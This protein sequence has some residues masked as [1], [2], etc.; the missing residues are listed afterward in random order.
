MNGLYR[1]DVDTQKD[2]QLLGCSQV[3]RLSLHDSHH[4]E[5]HLHDSLLSSTRLPAGFDSPLSALIFCQS[6]LSALIS[7]SLSLP[8]EIHY[9]LHPVAESP[10]DYRNIRA[11]PPSRSENPRPV[12]PLADRGGRSAVGLHAFRVPIS[13][14]ASKELTV[15]FI[16]G[17]RQFWVDRIYTTVELNGSVLC[18]SRL[19]G[20]L[21][22]VTRETAGFRFIVN[23]NS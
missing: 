6:P 13:T 21:G 22:F 10:L 18:R 4:D 17:S 3:V 11:L 5:R 15:G 1:R 16:L 14:G 7:P 23:G 20:V 12:S 19:L 9:P 8:P 2:G